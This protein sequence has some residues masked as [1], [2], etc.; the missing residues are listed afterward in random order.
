MLIM[1]KCTT[2]ILCYAFNDN[3][4]YLLVVLSDIE[5]FLN[6]PLREQMVHGDILG[7]T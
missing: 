4:T 3:Y 6:G 2:A 7:L 1:H 5:S